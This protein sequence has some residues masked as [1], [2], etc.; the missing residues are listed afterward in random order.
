MSVYLSR[1]E[2]LR[3]AMQQ[4]QVDAY[5][6]FS[7]DPHLS[8]YLPD[9]YQGRAWLSGFEGSAGSL[10]V[11]AD[12]AGLWTD[13]R[14]WVQ[15]ETDLQDSGFELMRWGDGHT[16]EMVDW[17]AAH[18][19]V[20]QTVA[21]DGQ[22]VALSQSQ[23]WQKMAD[24]S[25]LTLDQNVDLLAPI[26]PNRPE[27]P[28]APLFVHEP[29][30]CQRHVSDNLQ[31]VR[32]QMQQLGAQTHLISSLDDLAWL[33]NLRG[34][35]VAYNPVFLAHALISQDKATLFIDQRKITAQVAHYLYQQ[36]I[37]VQPY[38][39]LAEA[40]AELSDS[41]TLLVNPSAVTVGV[42]AAAKQVQLIQAA[43]PSTLLKACK[44]QA[45]IAQ[46]RQTMAQDGAALCEFFAW[47]EQTVLTRAVTE[48]EVDEQ[49][50][51]A[52]ARRPHFISPSFGTIAAFGP[53]GA[54]PHYQATP[55]SY[56]E[57][58]GDGL[59]LI[60]SGGQYAGG[61]TD[62]TRVVPVGTPTAEQ[63]KDYT[64]VLKGMISLSMA[65]FAK[66]V[67]GQQLDVVAR[68]PL[69]Q[70]G[71]DFGHG[72][73]HGVGYFLNVHEGPQSI[74][75]RTRPGAQPQPLQ[76]GMITSN[77]PGLYRANQWGIRIEN[78]IVCVP[79][80]RNEFAEL[81]A[82]ETLTLCPIDTRCI[83]PMVLTMAEV[84]WLN[85]YH[86]EV[87]VRL[88]PLVSGEALA[89][90]EQRTQPLATTNCSN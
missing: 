63:K 6:V 2:Q 66:G 24:Q 55:D 83:D 64:L 57:I 35:D 80:L 30:F 10:V 44:N 56:S 78:L 28:C 38:S 75:W 41:T 89:W 25:G 45:E 84:Q 36:N 47:F 16:P 62:I 46:V 39:S 51:A 52:R 5:V 73:G 40:L 37:E 23:T 33:F 87:Y 88:A 50:T 68:M 65:V 32:S 31:A 67:T 12:F 61:T 90:L 74:S 58:T 29:P 76:L 7:S 77:E 8:E 27:L 13:S 4:A 9:Y 14:Y 69:W 85:Q 86:Q 54:M 72:T 22:V 19:P 26:W 71:L 53:N 42:L 59:L 81:Y 3:S 82:F 1:L 49:I 17:V 20:G 34:S 21:F 15:A 18:L 43:N 79:H 60:D 70:A 48:L 11:T